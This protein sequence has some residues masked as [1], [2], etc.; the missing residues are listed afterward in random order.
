[1]KLIDI[2]AD[3]PMEIY[4]GKIRE[5][6]EAK[7]VEI[8]SDYQELV[9]EML[10]D[11]GGPDVPA[12]KFVDSHHCFKL[13]EYTEVHY[14]LESAIQN[15]IE[16]I[17]EKDYDSVNGRPYWLGV[18]I[19]ND[20]PMKFIADYSSKCKEPLAFHSTEAIESWLPYAMEALELQDV[21]KTESEM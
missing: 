14:V 8:K 17:D 5:C 11:I 15:L 6:L 4:W 16:L 12:R 19:E 7:L 9:D 21:R 20:N 3:L 10:D 18:V 13:A 2:D 1:M